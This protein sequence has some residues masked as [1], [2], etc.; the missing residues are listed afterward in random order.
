MK[1]HLLLF[2]AGLFTVMAAVGVYLHLYPAR[3][4]QVARVNA[5][6]RELL[7]DEGPNASI[8]QKIE[9][10]RLIGQE[11]EKMTPEQ[12]GEVMQNGRQ[13]FFQ[14]IDKFYALPAADRQ[15]YLDGEINKMEMFRKAAAAMQGLF[16][17][18]KSDPK[19]TLGPRP[20]QGTPEQRKQWIRDRLDRTTPQERAKALE[21]FHAIGERRKERGL[22][23]LGG[24]GG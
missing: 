2:T 11:M 21:Y 7:T 6:G 5:L 4:E 18:G 17:K 10:F 8:A 22:P 16:G 3:D 23:A 19:N 1:R 12:R 13:I 9:T 15:K 24:P 20:S 14:Q